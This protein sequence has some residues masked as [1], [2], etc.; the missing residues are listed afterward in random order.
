MAKD[1]MLLSV[2]TQIQVIRNMV[3]SGLDFDY[4]TRLAEAV[5]SSTPETVMEMSRR[6]LQ[7]ELYKE[8]I[9]GQPT[10]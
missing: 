10:D 5:R 4:F 9:S 7:P 2:L 1:S 8:I 6:Y 3:L